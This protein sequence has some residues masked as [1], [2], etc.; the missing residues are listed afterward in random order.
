[1]TL[2]NEHA[3]LNAYRDSVFTVTDRSSSYYRL[4]VR[5]AP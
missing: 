3:D 4:S 5:L 1:M 2:T